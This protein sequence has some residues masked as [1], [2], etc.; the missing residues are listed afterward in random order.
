M[1]ILAIII[2]LFLILIILQDSFE[3]IVL[4]RRVSRRFRLSRMFYV[5][6]WL[7]WSALARKLKPG[8][9]REMY[10]SYFGPMSLILLL[11]IWATILIFAFAL[12]QWGWGSAFRGPE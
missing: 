8:N 10:L 9:R 1:R 11:I 6:S 7:L 5:S 3:S 2:G 12:M 4:P